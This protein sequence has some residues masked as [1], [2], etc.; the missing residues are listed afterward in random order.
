M[1]WYRVKDS[2]STAIDK[3]NDMLMNDKQVY[4]GVFLY[5]QDRDIY[6]DAL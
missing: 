2:K 3:L 4:V 5:K 1:K 6:R